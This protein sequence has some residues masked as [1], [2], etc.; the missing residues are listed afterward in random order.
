MKRISLTLLFVIAAAATLPLQAQYYPYPYPY[1]RRP[2]NSRTGGATAPMQG[3]NGTFHGTVKQLTKKELVIT[4]S[5]DQDVVIRVSRKTRY[6][7]EGKEIKPAAI[8]QGTLV[9]VDAS[10]DIDAKP[11]AAIITVETLNK[12]KPSSE[13][14]ASDKPTDGK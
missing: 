13:K 8:E 11:T 7:K 4:N 2:A 10:E 14:A 9:S 6:L 1:P 12:E 3:L 5:E